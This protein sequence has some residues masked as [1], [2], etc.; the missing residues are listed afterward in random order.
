MREGDIV[1]V[2][3]LGGIILV[4]H[5]RIVGRGYGMISPASQLQKTCLL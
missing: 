5:G 1:T 2:V 4:V 3:T